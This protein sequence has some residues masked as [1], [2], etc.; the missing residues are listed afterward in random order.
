MIKPNDERVFPS[1]ILSILYLSWTIFYLMLF[2]NQ[3]LR[4]I[5]VRYFG[6][7]VHRP[8]VQTNSTAK[9]SIFS[10]QVCFG[11][12]ENGLFSAAR[13]TRPSRDAVENVVT[14]VG[15]DTSSRGSGRV[16]RGRPRIADKRMVVGQGGGEGTRKKKPTGTATP[17]APKTNDRRKTTGRGN[18]THARRGSA[19]P[20]SCRR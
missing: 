16:V 20:Q 5:V 17:V 12:L 19:P 1:T 8:E 7:F 10:R 13:V 2:Y 18:P 9:I 14:A 3:Y 4:S 11:F 15:D 6:C